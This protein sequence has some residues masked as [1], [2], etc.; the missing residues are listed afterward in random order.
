MIRR[1]NVPASDSFI[2]IALHRP[3]G[4]AK[5]NMRL[6]EVKFLAGATILAKIQVQISIFGLKSELKYNGFMMGFNIKLSTSSSHATTV[7]SPGFVVAVS[8]VMVLHNAF[9][10]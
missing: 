2:Y 6:L 1:N 3:V 9:L 7:H 10:R 4:N 5:F 8:L